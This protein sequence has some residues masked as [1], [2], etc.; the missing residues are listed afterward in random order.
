ME[1]TLFSQTNVKVQQDC[2]STALKE[3]SEVLTQVAWQAGKTGKIV[4]KIGYLGRGGTQE[5][6]E[7]LCRYRV[8]FE[9]FH[10]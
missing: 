10:P 4:V 1:H 8:H 3:Y 7:K 5:P 6:C 9:D 2:Q